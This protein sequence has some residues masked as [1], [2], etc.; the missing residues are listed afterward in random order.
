[1][2]YGQRRDFGRSNFGSPRGFAP[3]PVEVG[4]EYE[5]DVTETSRRGDGVARIQGFV[6]FVAGARAGQK[7][8]VKITNVSSRFANAE[9]VSSGTDE[10]PAQST[11]TT[12]TTESTGSTEQPTAE[13]T[14]QTDS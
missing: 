11:E 5:V 8:K 1:M 3:K 6:I 2:S 10:A 14:E 9:L 13:S 4:K 7:A 12:E